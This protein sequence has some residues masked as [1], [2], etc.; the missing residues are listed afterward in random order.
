MDGKLV[1]DVGVDLSYNPTYP[2][3]GVGSGH[4]H[5]TAALFPSKEERVPLS[6][7]PFLMEQ[8]ENRGKQTAD[9]VNGGSWHLRC[10]IRGRLL[11][12]KRKLQMAK[13]RDERKNEE[14]TEKDGGRSALE[15]VWIRWCRGLHRERRER[16]AEGLSTAAKERQ[17]EN[18]KGIA[19]SDRRESL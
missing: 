4:R 10:N 13:K 18:G 19:M 14:R 11:H 5:Q 3:P 8:R 17:G 15:E 2:I 9:N 1:V 16:T 12:G 7:F 6:L